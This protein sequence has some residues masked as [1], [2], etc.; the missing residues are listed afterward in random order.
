MDRTLISL[1]LSSFYSFSAVIYQSVG[2]QY[3]SGDDAKVIVW[4]Q[5]SSYL[6]FPD[7]TIT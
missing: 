7:V 4:E 5:D 6:A 1:D 3:A 2:R